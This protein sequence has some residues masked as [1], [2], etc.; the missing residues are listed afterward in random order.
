MRV[1]GKGWDEGF[2]CRERDWRPRHLPGWGCWRDERER[3]NVAAGRGTWGGNPDDRN[4]DTAQQIFTAALIAEDLATT[5]YYN[6]L[7]G[8]VIRIRTWRGLA[9]R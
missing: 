8:G 6:S 1:E 7:V 9:V 5:M 4:S 2:S 3:R